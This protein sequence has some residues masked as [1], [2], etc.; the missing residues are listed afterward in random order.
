M[1]A[2]IPDAEIDTDPDLVRALLREQHPDLAD[3]PLNL[4]GSGWDNDTYRLGQDLAVRL[5]RRELAAEL[6]LVEQKWLP[7]VAARIEVRT[8]A[9]VR[10]GRPNAS[11][12]WH[13]S[14]VPW[15]P[16]ESADL[17]PLA[18]SEASRLAHIL[19]SLHIDAP[20]EAPF[21]PRR[22]V[23]LVEREE[24]LQPQLDALD[25]LD[26]ARVDQLRTIWRNGVNAPAARHTVWIHGDLHPRN[27]VVREGRLAA[28]ID[29]GDMT[30]GDRAN[31]LACAWMLWTSG[32][33]RAEF[34]RVYGAAPPA[35]SR[36]RAW[37]IFFGAILS[38]SG[39]AGHEAMGVRILETL[40]AE[41]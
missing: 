16:G 30:A 28:L 13:W 34:F 14:V 29:W 33:A 26:S 4:L 2:L 25:H 36:A 40:L 38:R 10:V 6:I 18:L 3:E 21:N 20:S 39:E 22:G 11:Y 9:P 35:I 15:I 31:D 8:S 37:A 19:R 24:V 1:H 12:P 41:S 5:P 7:V 27:V 17:Q 23:P 32:E